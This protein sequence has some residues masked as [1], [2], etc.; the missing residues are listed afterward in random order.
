MA[1]QPNLP[2]IP[3]TKAANNTS[4][5]ATSPIEKETIK[6]NKLLQ[7]IDTYESRIK[8]YEQE[9][10]ELRKLFDSILLPEYNKLTQAQVEVLRVAEYTFEH[11]ELSRKEKIMFCDFV[12]EFIGESSRM[13]EELD[14]LETKYIELS[15]SLLSKKDRKSISKLFEKE[16]GVDVPVEGDL[17]FEGMFSNIGKDI[18]EQKHKQ[19]KESIQQQKATADLTS[20]TTTDLYKVLAKVLHP[21]LEKDETIRAKKVTLMQELSEAKNNKNIFAMLLI[22]QKAAPYLPISFGMQQYLQVDKLKALNNVLKER[23]N[24]LKRTIKAELEK[25]LYNMNSGYS[26][27]TNAKDDL[28]KQAKYIKKETKKILGMKPLCGNI[29]DLRILL[30][31]YEM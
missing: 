4:K 29:N 10:D 27:P 12:Q 17:D 11:N 15:Y 23:A 3:V 26:K 7:D 14:A 30:Y 31:T 9:E 19:Q 8:E 21:D 5:N 1:T 6:Y 25:K 2:L 22:Q 20:I 16:M 24:E 13:N 28:T 18:N